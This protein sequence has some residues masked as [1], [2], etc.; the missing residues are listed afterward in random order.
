MFRRGKKKQ[1]DPTRENYIKTKI[2][3]SLAEAVKV[4]QL[5]NKHS[6]DALAL[7]DSTARLCSVLEALFIH[8]L[9]STFLGRFPL[10]GGGD[11][12][13]RLPEPSFW[14]FALLYSHKQVISTIE[15]SSQIT[16]EVGKARSWLRL[17]LNDG[18]LVSYLL[19]MTR[20]TSALSVYYE[21]Y[22]MLR[23]LERMDLARSYVIG[24]EIYA[25]NLP[26]NVSMFNRWLP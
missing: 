26:T 13:P 12:S 16:T 23:D 3:D 22:A 25:F 8:G 20:D 4:I 9:K 11:L 5:E 19:T 17:A 2:L 1:Y 15:K 21:N 18:L 7:T 14:T 10:W 6:D 24:L